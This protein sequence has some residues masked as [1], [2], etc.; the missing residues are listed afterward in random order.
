MLEVIGLFGLV[1]FVG[2]SL[3]VGIRILVLAWRTQGLPEWLVGSSLVLAGALGTGLSV[4]PMLWPSLEAGAAYVVF[5]I[6]SIAN[7]VGYTLLFYFVWR[8][9]RPGQRW[10]AVFFV[11]CL[12]VLAVGGVG[13]GLTL[14]PGE[15]ISRPEGPARTW[16]MV[17]L[18]ARVAGYL[19]AA[20]ESFRYYAML[21]RRLKIGLG[22]PETA[23]RF[24]YW[25]VC[26]AAVVCIWATLVAEQMV[27]A[28]A[29]S[30][31]AI[32]LSSALLGFVVAGSLSL[33][34]FPG[35]RQTADASAGA[36]QAGTDGR[37]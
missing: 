14:L 33:A 36:A 7:H 17:S 24:F 6:G 2:V 34:F 10:A 27:P 35:R 22:D 8:V 28:V 31:G 30:R 20:I 37:G 11:L 3:I 26:T 15:S 13:L 4:L 5:Q 1:A 16:L 23:N 25:G 12:A 18:F 21:K 29:A 32:E 9:F 19:W